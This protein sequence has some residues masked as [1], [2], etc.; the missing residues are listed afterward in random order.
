MDEIGDMLMASIALRFITETDPDG[1]PWKPLAPATIEDR[2]KKGY[3]PGQ[4]LTRS[5]RLRSS[6]TRRNA[7]GFFCKADAT[8]VT[9]GTNVEYA[10]IHQHGGTIE[11]HAH[12]LLNKFLHFREVDAGAVSNLG[13]VKYRAKRFT[14]ENDKGKVAMARRVVGAARFTIPA[15]PFAGINGSDETAAVAI[16]R[17]HLLGTVG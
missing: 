3:W 8:S 17:K 14:K 4:M 13:P 12:T 6:I 2:K 5:G 1:N 11:R 7:D 15:R 10:A 9:V 16:L